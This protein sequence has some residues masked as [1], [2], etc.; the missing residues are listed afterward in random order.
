MDRLAALPTFM[1][2]Q[3][4]TEVS[5]SGV[6]TGQKTLTEGSFHRIALRNIP[7]HADVVGSEVPTHTHLFLPWV[8][9]CCPKVVAAVLNL[10]LQLPKQMQGNK[11]LDVQ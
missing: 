3:V 7:L 1:Q 9:M 4:P 6:P 8:Y 10:Q 11:C 2:R 5:P